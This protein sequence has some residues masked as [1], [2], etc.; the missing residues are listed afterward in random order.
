[1]HTVTYIHL[2]LHYECAG[3]CQ[4]AVNQPHTRHTHTQQSHHSASH[5]AA[6]PF[7]RLHCPGGM[8]WDGMGNAPESAH[9]VVA[10]MMHS[11]LPS[12]SGLAST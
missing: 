10:G 11:R 1:M 9:R 3:Q 8:G 6:R 2:P 12:N 7:L 5:R 4:P